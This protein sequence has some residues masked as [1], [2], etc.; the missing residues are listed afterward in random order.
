MTDKERLR[1][2][3]ADLKDDHLTCRD[4]G[5]AWR[6]DSYRSVGDDGARYYLR[7]LVCRVCKTHREEEVARDGELLKRRYRYRKGYQFEKGVVGVGGLPKF[8]FR[9]EWLRRITKE[10]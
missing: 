2:A 3:I 9:S 7:V 10:S 8:H 5:H 4:L 1:G 6:M